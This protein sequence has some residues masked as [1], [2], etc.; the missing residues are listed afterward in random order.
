ML[1]TF[2]IPP[3]AIR[4][5]R[6]HTIT[7]YVR[8]HI[9]HERAHPGEDGLSRLIEAEQRGETTI[10]EIINLLFTTLT[11]STDTSSAIKSHL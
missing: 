6:A 1:E 11:E 2:S 3:P 4:L 5:S 10:D 7:C 9:E 8:D